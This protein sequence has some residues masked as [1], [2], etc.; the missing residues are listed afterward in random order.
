MVVIF[1]LISG[2]NAM[3]IGRRNG[4]ETFDESDVFLLTLD[5]P[6][7]DDGFGFVWSGISVDDGV[8]EIGPLVIR[9]V[10]KE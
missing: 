7:H 5:I 4:I 8:C 1:V 6:K 3:L 2:Q 10:N 9:S